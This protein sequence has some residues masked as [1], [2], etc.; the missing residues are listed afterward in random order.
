M[1][2]LEK[3]CVVCCPSDQRRCHQTGLGQG[4]PRLVVLGLDEVGEVLGLLVAVVVMAVAVVVVLGA[5]VLHLVDAAALGA[6]L[7]G[8]VA[9]DLDGRSCAL[10]LIRSRL[11]TSVRRI[12]QH[13]YIVEV[14]LVEVVVIGGGR[15]VSQMT[16]WESTG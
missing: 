1:S 11:H 13:C 6:A 12:L 8:A 15:T 10:A 3:V 16:P 7:D 2:S 4:T 14:G 5:D 9:G